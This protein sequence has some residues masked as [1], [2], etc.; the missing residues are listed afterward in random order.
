MRHAG[1]CLLPTMQDE[2]PKVDP[3]R[4]SL[5]KGQA[6]PGLAFP[7][8]RLRLLVLKAERVG[9]DVERPA[10]HF[11]VNPAQVLADDPQE[12]ELNAA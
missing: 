11:V 6:S 1:Y 8:C 4:F 5:C 10:L 2:S 9:H 3:A 12:N 7:F